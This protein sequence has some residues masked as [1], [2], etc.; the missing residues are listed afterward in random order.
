MVTDD[1]VAMTTTARQ[2][3]FF[4]AAQPAS[5]SSACACACIHTIVHRHSFP[6]EPRERTKPHTLP[7]LAERDKNNNEKKARDP[8][9]SHLHPSHHLKSKAQLGPL[10]ATTTTLRR[11]VLAQPEV[12]KGSQSLVG[13]WRHPD[14]DGRLHN[15]FGPRRFLSTRSTSTDDKGYC[16]ALLF[17]K[18]LSSNS[19]L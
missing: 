13:Q 14:Q 16:S 15:S 12:S 3:S 1:P 18:L 8:A 6:K 7:S 19:H 4:A 5:L 9:P 10:L 17:S 2:P 11:S